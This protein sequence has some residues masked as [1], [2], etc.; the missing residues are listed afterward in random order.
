MRSI[1]FAI[2][3][4]L[5]GAALL[6]I[7]IVLA[8]PSSPAAMPI[9]GAGLL[10]MDSFFPLT[11]EPGPTGLNNADPFL[12]TAVCRLLGGGCSGSLRRARGRALLVACDLRQRVERGLQHERQTAVHGDLDLVVA[13]PTSSSSC[14]SRRPKLAQSIMIEMKD[15]EGYAVLR[16]LAPLDSF[17]DLVRTFLAESRC[18]ALPA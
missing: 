9:R 5:V 12:R 16:A 4:G 1:I 3:V 10:E 15:E 18:E 17:E 7:V 13:T 2:L 8:L 6:H 11:A 14:A